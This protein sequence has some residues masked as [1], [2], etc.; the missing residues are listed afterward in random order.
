MKTCSVLVALWSLWSLCSTTPTTHFDCVYSCQR[1]SCAA[2]DQPTFDGEPGLACVKMNKG[3]NNVGVWRWMCDWYA[4]GLYSGTIKQCN[5]TGCIPPWGCKLVSFTTAR[6]EC[7]PK[8]TYCD[9]NSGTKKVCCKNDVM[10]YP[11][12]KPCIPALP[13]VKNTTTHTTAPPHTPRPPISTI[14]A[15][16]VVSGVILLAIIGGIIVWVRRRMERQGYGPIQNA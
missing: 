5:Q 1:G 10:C 14:I 6:E 2:R 7:T 12:H 16:S 4:E 8:N 11:N 15:V 3:G 9:P 13:I